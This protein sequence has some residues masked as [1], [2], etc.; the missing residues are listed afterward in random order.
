METQNN[1]KRTVAGSVGA[2]MGAIFNG[3]GRTYYIL[4]HKTSS[5]YHSAGESQKIIIDQIEIGRDASC[6]VR[7][8]ESFDTVSRKHAAIVRDGNNWQLIHL[9]QSNPTLVNGRPIQGT[10]YLQSGDEI[11][12]SVNGPRLGFIQPQGKQGLTSSIKLTERM[13][14]F[15]QQALRPYRRAI[16]ALSALLLLV[17]LGFGAWN[18]KLTLDNKALRQEMALYQAQVDSLGMEKLKLDNMEQQLTAQLAADPNNQEVKQQLGQVQQERVRVVYAYNNA[19][20]RLAS[21]KAKMA[22]YGF[23]EDDEDIE[24][25]PKG[26]EATA[27]VAAATGGQAGLGTTGP[28]TDGE[29]RWDNS[30]QAVVSAEG[31]AVNP[32]NRNDFID[33]SNPT[34]QESAQNSAGASDNIVN[35]YN[36]IYTLKVKRITLERDGNSY[37]PG[38][39]TSQLVVGTGFVIGG[40]FI[41]ARSNLQP[42]VYRNVYRSDWRQLLA[43]YVAAGF[44]VI[45]DF[46]AYSTRGSGHPLRFSN[47]QFD[48]AS[49]EA[50]DG[51]DIVELRKDVVKRVKQWG[52][53]IKYTKRTREQF[54]VTYYTDN[55]HNAASLALGA[56][57]GLP[58]DI[59][60]AQSLKGS[61][62]VVIA[63]F[64]GRTDIQVLSNYIKYFTSRTS[65]LAARFI[66]L[67]DASTNFGFTGSP[68]FFKESN[69]SYRVVGVNVGNF[70]GEVRIVPIH[71]VR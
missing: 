62:E 15:R 40:K 25:G 13:N 16:W 61:E 67:Q 69:G 12:L 47:T 59:P 2:G 19:S 1:Y 53:D 39:A 37:D 65:R 27:A 7:Y 24:A 56:P 32:G 60:T 57:G 55:S 38:I 18:Y 28:I 10:Y 52:V 17:I 41:T 68:A 23:D 64:S 36:D 26:S 63:G 58:V 35:Y 51:K 45:I 8:D 54:V 31:V 50:Y 43:E 3:S 46:E 29:E 33:K 14:L 11:Q 71:R 4:E 30:E 20:Q 9:S 66:T 6:Q 5:K 49:L 42:W 22:E 70:G 21:T 48:L 44:H 34:I